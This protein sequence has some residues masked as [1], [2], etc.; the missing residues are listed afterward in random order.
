MPQLTSKIL[1]EVTHDS[2]IAPD[3]VAGY[4]NRM[5]D[6]GYADLTDSAD[7]PN[8]DAA[9][10]REYKQIT[11]MTIGVPEAVAAMVTNRDLAINYIRQLYR[12][13]R[14]VRAGIA[15]NPIRGIPGDP[16]DPDAYLI[17]RYDEANGWWEEGLAAA[18]GRV[19]RLPCV[20]MI[21]NVPAASGLK[22]EEIPRGK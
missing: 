14:K 3:D 22:W 8:I 20:L 19:E 2:K 11:A 17:G 12:E 21:N 9:M 18:N 1:I 15:R 5:L 16:G 7:D 13:N 4:I 10:R 6:V